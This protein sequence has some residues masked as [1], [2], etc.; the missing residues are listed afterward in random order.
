[1]A[2]PNSS[3][4]G[5][6]LFGKVVVAAYYDLTG[7]EVAERVPCTIYVFLRLT[8][9][10]RGCPSLQFRPS[11][12]GEADSD[13]RHLRALRSRRIGEPHRRVDSSLS[14]AALVERFYAPRRSFRAEGSG[15]V[16]DAPPFPVGGDRLHGLEPTFS[17]ERVGRSGTELSQPERVLINGTFGEL[18]CPALQRLGSLLEAPGHV[19]VRDVRHAWDQ[20]C[21]EARARPPVWIRPRL[22]IGRLGCGSPPQGRRRHRSDRAATSLGKVSSTSRPFVSAS[23]TAARSGPQ[24]GLWRI[25]ARRSGPR[26]ERSSNSSMRCS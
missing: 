26:P 17:G 25:A 21:D 1:M 15:V 13:R 7:D 2:R 6:T 8:R 22:P 3:R 12:Q 11:I 10:S 16:V 4:S 24:A 19:G 5:D 18:V 20:A 9:A 23:R 14:E